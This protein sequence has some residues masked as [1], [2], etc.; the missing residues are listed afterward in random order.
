MQR[1]LVFA[2]DAYYPSGGWKDFVGSYDS[3][4]RALGIA[5]GIARETFKW[6]HVFDT[7]TQKILQEFEA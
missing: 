1:F 3:A 2:G 6:A 5:E 7:E 4:D